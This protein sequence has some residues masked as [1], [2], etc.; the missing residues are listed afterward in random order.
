MYRAAW[1]ASLILVVVALFTLGHADTPKLS[2][3]PVSF[4][5]GRAA[6][7]MRTIVQDFPQRVAGSDPDNRMAIWVAQQFKDA[8]LQTHLDGYAA[9][10]N[11]KGVALQNVWATSKGDTPG[12]ILV[13]A[14]RDVQG[15]ATQGANDNASG[16]AAML[17]LA[18]AFTVTA[19]HHTIVFLCSSGDAF[20]A[21][22]AHQFA[23]VHASAD[24]WA[25]IA[26]RQ[27]ATKDTTG[28]GLDGWSAA[29]KVAPPWLWLLSAPAAR[30]NANLKTQLPTIASQVL[31]LSVPTSSGSQ[32]PFVALGV[33]AITVSAAGPK[34]PPVFDTIDTTS[35]QTL[36]KLGDTVQAMIMSIDANPTAGS[37]SGGTIFLTR[38]RTL[39]G[40]ALAAILAALLIPLAAV[41][42]DLFAHCQRSRI[43]IRPA[44]VRSLLHLAPWV[45]L[46][47]IVYLANLI[48]LLPKSP[49]AVIP[50][51]S[52]IADT[53]RYLR[54]VVLLALLVLA[55]AYAVAVERRLER[56]VRTDPRATIFTAHLLLV[57][58]ALLAFVVNPY[59]IL[60]VV[61]AAVLWP[62]ARPG[63]WMRSIL[64]AYLG[65]A[66]IPVVLVY[67]ASRLGLGFKVWW[68]FFLLLENRTI[69]AG[70]VLLGIVFLSTA[71][72]LAHTLHERGLAP[73]ALTWPAVDRR[74]L[75]RP[76]NAQWASAHAEEAQR[77]RHAGASVR[78]R[79]PQPPG[80]RRRPKPGDQAP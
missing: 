46:L 29:P 41:T 44:L 56:R 33:P 51:G 10:V 31:R 23:E 6:A 68:Y 60:L 34:Q 17:E 53:P 42:V 8:G 43:R 52:H 72:M 3:E 73:G 12:S 5:G 79:R 13:I 74:A 54:V 69:P 66:M 78:R 61:P 14:N 49:G 32:G 71:G 30:V 26:L 77:R 24:L 16:V 19:H 70:S 1:V 63:G 58:I 11:G 18:R 36:T 15:L 28:I 62:L 39:P 76:S 80:R 75:D 67:Y 40:G 20:G 27:L 9:T 2:T 7:D 22:G 35:S 45:V 57:L 21:L 55:Y 47:V 38:E 48:G 37:P 64:P 65:L 50:P 4:D 59:A 25:V